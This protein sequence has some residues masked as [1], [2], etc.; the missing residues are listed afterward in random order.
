VELAT[1]RTLQEHQGMLVE[2]QSHI[3]NSN[4]HYEKNFNFIGLKSDVWLYTPL[5]S[6]IQYK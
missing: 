5:M 1:E 3:I 6:P 4:D 2:M